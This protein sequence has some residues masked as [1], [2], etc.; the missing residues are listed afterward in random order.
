MFFLQTPIF[1]YPFPF[2]KR[3]GTPEKQG[4][5]RNPKTKSSKHSRLCRYHVFSGG[6]FEHKTCGKDVFSEGDFKDKSCGK[7]VFSV[8]ASKDKSCR[9][10]VC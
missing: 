1:P 3:I 9:K 5:A 4:Q 7:D 8:G 10:D 6:A 2:W